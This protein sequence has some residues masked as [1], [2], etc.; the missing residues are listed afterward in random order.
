LTSIVWF[1]QDLRIHDHLPFTNASKNSGTKILGLYVLPDFNEIMPEGFPRWSPLRIRFL[2]ESLQALD[3]QLKTLG[4][5]LVL[6]KGPASDAFKH[7]SAAVNIQKIYAYSYP[8]VEEQEDEQSLI[9]AG[10]NLQLHHGHSLIH[11]DD[12]PFAINNLPKVFTAFRRKVEEKILIRPPLSAPENLS[13]F[14]TQIGQ[15]VET[16]ASN[17]ELPVGHDDRSSIPFQGGEISGL[18]RLHGYFSNTE[19]ASNY[20]QTRNQLNGED[21]STKFSLWL[22]NGS[23]SPRLIYKKLKAFEA[24]YGP[25]DSTYWIFFELLWRDFFF[26][27]AL[28]QGNVFFG[29]SKR[30]QMINPRAL[31]FWRN[32]ETSDAF[33]NAAMNELKMTGYMSNRLRQNVASYLIHH[34]N[35]DWVSGARYFESQLIDYDCYSNYGNWTYLAGKGNDPRP[36]RVFNP[37]RQA[38]MYDSDGSFQKLW[39][40]V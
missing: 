15:S 40:Q 16:L 22:A 32:G 25:N 19:L 14:D 36:D 7:V 29:F 24:D 39:Q 20:K 18:Q 11:P 3:L 4:G 37:E 21:F 34:L 2:L 23:L 27:N 31:D 9:H 13:F 6:L 38:S 35:G 30:H 33:I 5:R 12:L 10:F 26:F 17:F 8:G 1:R 28:K